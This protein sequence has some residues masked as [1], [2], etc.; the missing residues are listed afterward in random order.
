MVTVT[1]TVRVSI[2]EVGFG[3]VGF[4]KVGFDDVGFDDVGFDDVGFG[5]VEFSE[6]G[7]IG[8]IPINVDKPQTLVALSMVSIG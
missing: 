2:G 7:Q 8:N 6:V 5:E 1:V 4:G 3:E